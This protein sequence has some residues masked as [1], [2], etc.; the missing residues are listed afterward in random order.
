MAHMSGVNPRASRGLTDAPASSNN[1]TTVG[2]ASAR[3]VIEDGSG[4]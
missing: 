3:K 4:A 1:F 2:F